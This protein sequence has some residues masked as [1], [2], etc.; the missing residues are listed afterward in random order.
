M[1]LAPDRPPC[2][3]QASQTGEALV[4]ELALRRQVQNTCVLLAGSRKTDTAVDIKTYLLIKNIFGHFLKQPNS[5][6]LTRTALKLGL[7]THSQQ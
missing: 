5:L 1:L 3:K 2:D 4:A 6:N 7:L